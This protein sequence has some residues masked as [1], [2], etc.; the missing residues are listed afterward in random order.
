MWHSYCK[1]SNAN[2]GHTGRSPPTAK[3]TACSSRYAVMVPSIA[4]RCVPTKHYNRTTKK[5]QKHCSA[6]SILHYKKC[7]QLALL[8]VEIELFV[9]E[10]IAVILVLVNKVALP[11]GKV[12]GKHTGIVIAVH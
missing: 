7:L 8:F 2:N 1:N 9:V 5:E 4:H 11:V 3:A 12:I 6:P 10:I